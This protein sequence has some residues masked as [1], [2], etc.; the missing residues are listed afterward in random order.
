MTSAE[1]AI[2]EDAALRLDFEAV[3]QLPPVRPVASVSSLRLLRAFRSDMLAA[4]SADTYSQLRVSFRRLGRQFIVLSDPDDINHV[5][6]AHLDRYQ[7]NVLARRLLEPIVGGGLV[8]AEGEEWERQHRQLIPA[9]QPRHIDRLV[10]AFH[11]TA[12][13]HVASW[14]DGG[15][16][17]RNLLID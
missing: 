10:P 16:V 1:V 6:N 7:P 4:F 11:V 9:F 14:S 13:S 3:D 2:P 17:E 5:L 8:L 15:V 12:T